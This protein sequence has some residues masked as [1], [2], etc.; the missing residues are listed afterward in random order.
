MGI[1]YTGRAVG[2]GKGIVE[3]IGV[4]IIYKVVGMGAD[5]DVVEDVG[6]EGGEEDVG[7]IYEGVV[8]GIGMG[9]GVGFVSEGSVVG[10]YEGVMG[11]VFSLKI[12]LGNVGDIGVGIIYKGVNIDEDVGKNE[13]E[14]VV[15]GEDVGKD[16][17]DG[18]VVKGVGI[19]YKGVVEHRR[20]R[21][22][23]RR[24]RRGRCRKNRRGHH[25]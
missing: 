8:G 19:I 14:D 3:G 4:G 20:G 23:H 11:V 5:D 7:I 2:F 17:G 21:G 16:V 10:G 18:S 6:D 12:V 22:S 24:H 15:M 1:I 13:G 25:L 9:F